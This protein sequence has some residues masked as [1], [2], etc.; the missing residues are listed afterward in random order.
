MNHNHV[1]H[2][3]HL[4]FNN[5]KCKHNIVIIIYL[6]FFILFIKLKVNYTIAST[7]IL[8]FVSYIYVMIPILKTI[9]N[10]KNIL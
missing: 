4:D 10:D 9:I 6:L 7:K 5:H 1:T 3:D 2:F 8:N